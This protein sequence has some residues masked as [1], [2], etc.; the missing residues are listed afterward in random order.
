MVRPGTLAEFALG[1]PSRGG[2]MVLLLILVKD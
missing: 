1:S 2:N